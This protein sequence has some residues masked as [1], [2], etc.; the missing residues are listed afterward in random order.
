MTDP[1]AA[2]TA[3]Q[4]SLLAN[5]P[6]FIETQFPVAKVSVESYRERTAKQSQTLT[7]L[8]KWWGRKPLILV[9]AA[10]LG[11]LMPASNDPEKDRDIF[12]KLLTM[13]KEGLQRRKSKAIPQERLL[14]E[15]RRMPPSI[16]KRFLTSGESISVLNLD[17]SEKEELQLLVFDRMPYSEKQ[18]YCDRPEQ[19]EGPSVETWQEINSYLGTHGENLYELVQELGE[20][21]FGHRPRVGDVFCGGGSIPFEAARLGCDAFGSDLNPVAAALTWGAMNVVG[22]GKEAIEKITRAKEGIITELMDQYQEWGVD[23]N[24]LGWHAE[25]YLYC[26]EITDPETGW[27]IPLLPSMAISVF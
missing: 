5:A 2:Q 9:R 24:S 10:L 16:Q 8:G 20:R 22:G 3:H 12:L 11:L 1:K 14:E 7:G 19:I 23:R 6:C 21:R 4:D 26:I 18:G 13:D 17:K 25:Y 27:K 15:L